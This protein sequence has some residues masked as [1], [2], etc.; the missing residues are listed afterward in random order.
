MLIL[1]VKILPRLPRLR[2]YECNN[3]QGVLLAQ[4]QNGVMEAN[5]PLC[6]KCFFRI[7]DGELPSAF[8]VTS[9]PA[10]AAEAL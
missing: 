9:Q 7:S 10:P 2:C 1:N 8:K 5:L 3:Q 6:E 4:V